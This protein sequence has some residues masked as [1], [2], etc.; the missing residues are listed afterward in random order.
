MMKIINKRH[1]DL[2]VVLLFATLIIP[3]I[4]RYCFID[5]PDYFAHMR[6]IEGKAFGDLISLGLPHLTVHYILLNISNVFNVT[7]NTTFFV[8]TVLSILGLA[9]VKV[10]FVRYSLPN[11]EKYR[12]GFLAGIT[13]LMGAIYFPL[14]NSYSYLGIWSPLAYHNPTSTWLKPVA[15]LTIFIY[16]KLLDDDRKNIKQSWLLALLIFLGAVIKPNFALCFIPVL[17]MDML[18]RKKVYQG[19][20]IILPTLCVLLG[21][22]LITFAADIEQKSSVVFTLAGPWSVYSN[23][24]L[25]AII[26]N[27]LAPILITYTLFKIEAFSHKYKLIWSIV[28]VALLQ[29]LFLAESGHRYEG[30]NFIWGYVVAVDILFLVSVVEFTRNIDSYSSKWKKTVVSI[31]ALHAICGLAFIVLTGVGR[32]PFSV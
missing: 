12:V 28:L 3:S 14:F 24:I 29:G 23:N 27:L 15:L 10:L 8:F 31:L 5:G 16:F 19:V 7:L 21:Q 22:Y 32:G 9:I 4:Y 20:L 25:G 30:M 17:F 2:L 6:F 18:F 13:M 26:Q 11:A 1:V